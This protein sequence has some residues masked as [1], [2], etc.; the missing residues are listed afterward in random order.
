MPEEQP[1]TFVAAQAG[2]GSEL[3][4]RFDAL[5]DHGHPECVGHRR[6]GGDDLAVAGTPADVLNEAAVDFQ[7]VRV[8]SLK[9]NERGIAGPEVIK[10]NA[11]ADRR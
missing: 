3:M 9:I 8:Q 7:D 2:Q 6:H 10:G 5:A 1:L 11:H 4:A